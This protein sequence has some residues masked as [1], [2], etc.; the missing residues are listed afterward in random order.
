MRKVLDSDN[1]DE[2]VEKAN[3]IG[4][5]WSVELG[6]RSRRMIQT[7]TAL[8]TIDEARDELAKEM[9]P[10]TWGRQYAHMFHWF[11]GDLKLVAYKADGT[12]EIIGSAFTEPEAFQRLAMHKKDNAFKQASV[13]RRVD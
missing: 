2:I 5:T 3:N 8:I 6:P 9:V 12:K 7:E 4:R 11:Q 13:L 10:D 1:S